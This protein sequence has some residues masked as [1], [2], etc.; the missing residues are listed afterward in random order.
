M[1]KVQN[2]D[3][4]LEIKSGESMGGNDGAPSFKNARKARKKARLVKSMERSSVLRKLNLVRAIDEKAYCGPTAETKAK[5]TEDPLVSFI[6]KKILDDEQVRAFKRIKRAVQVITDGTQVRTSRFNAVSVQTGRFEGLS[7]SEYEIKLTEDYTRWI[8]RM[9][10]AH[11]Q[12]GPILDVIIDEMSLRGIDR[13]WG[14]RKGWAKNHLQTS[15][16]L[17]APFYSLSDR[18]K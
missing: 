18:H 12:A 7:E 5:L 4:V 1:S 10:G 11:L 13:K 14:K 9:T 16:D 3:S 17:Y 2:N 8:D 6:H 15:L